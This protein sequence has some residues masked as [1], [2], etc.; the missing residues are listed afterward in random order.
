MKR[1]EFIAGLGSAV[2]W[3]VVARAQQG[4]RVRRIGVLMPYDE[5]DPEPKRRVSAFN[6]FRKRARRLRRLGSDG[7]V[8]SG[9]EFRG[10]GAA[11]VSSR[12]PP[13]HA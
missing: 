11:L 13:R 5:N 2:A 10:A 3:P 1:R 6:Q 7:D 4:D 8:V 9:Q 12:G